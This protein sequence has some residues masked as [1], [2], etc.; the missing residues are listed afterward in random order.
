MLYNKTVTIYNRYSAGLPPLPPRI[1]YDKTVIKNVYWE[2]DVQTN[3]N[4][5]GRPTITQTALILIP[6][7]ADQS[8][9]TYIDPSKFASMPNDTQNFW[10]ATPDPSNPDFVVLG[11]GR[12]ITDLYTI[13]NLRRDFKTIVIHGVA[14]MF[15]SPVLPHLEIRGL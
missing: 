12:D 2:D 11:E 3:P 9:K 15:E 6:K 10:T 1:K 8:G 7:G 5:N 14:N 4:S 13:E